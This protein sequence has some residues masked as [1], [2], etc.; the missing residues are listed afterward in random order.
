MAYNKTKIV[1]TA[2]KY[3]NQG[4]VSQAIA[5]YQPILK[6]EP[7]D[8]VTLMTIG[9]LYVRQGE[10]FQA[11]EYFERLAQ[12]FLNDGFVTKAIAIYK[13]IAKLAPEESKPLER[14]AELYVQQ[15]VM[16]EARPLYLQLAEVHLE[17]SRH[18]QA[19]ALLQKLLEAEP[20]NLR[21]RLRLGELYH[22]MGRGTESTEMFF[23]AAE[24]QLERRE[25][26]EAE[27]LADRALKIDSDHAA[28]LM[29][30]ARALAGLG[31]RVDAVNLLEGFPGW[32]T[33]S[34]PAVL[35]IEL[36]LQGGESARASKLAGQVVARDPKN[37]EL[38]YKVATA[39]VENSE[40]DTALELLGT[41]RGI[42]IDAG[43]H[44]RLAHAL[45]AAAER[46]KGRLEPLEWL[47]GL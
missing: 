26:G 40:V 21:V 9:D 14:L 36:Y 8:Q 13:K 22:L 47:G 25:F 3:L 7:K 44:E 11:L 1:E 30:K 46:Q 4:K 17:A 23:G 37:F 39:L 32:D 18:P 33:G 28:A 6:H 45:A 15:G 42:M 10:T 16:S 38:A 41:I 43:D 20:D 19:V 24:R 34:K 35:L 31:K 2:Q 29:V 27:R 12:I 5:E